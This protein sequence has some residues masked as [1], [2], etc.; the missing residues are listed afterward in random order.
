M[1]RR[2]SMISYISMAIGII[3]G[4]SFQNSVQIGILKYRIKKV[5]KYDIKYN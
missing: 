4:I 2:E 5:E 3:A 1:D